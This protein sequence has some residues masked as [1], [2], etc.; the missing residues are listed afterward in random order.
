MTEDARST[1]SGEP[2]DTPVGPPPTVTP[3]DAVGGPPPTDGPTPAPPPPPTQTAPAGAPPPPSGTTTAVMDPPP[4]PPP[5]VVERRRDRP[6]MSLLPISLGVGLLAAAIVLSAAR[7]RSDGDLDWSNYTVGL[8]AT[9][10]LVLVALVSLLGG[11]GRTREELATW[12]G[13]IGVLGVGAMLGVGLEDVSGADDWLPYLVGGVV[14]LL[15]VLGYVAIRRGAFVV[16]AILGLGLVYLQAC[17]D[18]LSDIGDDDGAIVA[19]AA[20]AVFVLVVTAVGW[21]LPTRALSGVVAGVVGVIGFNGVLLVLVIS[22][23]FAPFFSLDMIGGEDG[24]ASGAEGPKADFDTD[25]YVILALAAVLTLVWALAA[26]LN[27][28]PGFTVL[29]IAMPASVVPTATFVLVVDHP[30]WW[31]A[32]LAVA[33][34]LVLALVGLQQ[35]LARKRRA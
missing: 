23:A 13:A 14:V 21:I 30:T 6:G 34:T 19:A 8:G 2:K 28:N 3:A 12:P 11:V 16:T 29:A 5:A 15:S 31:G 26:A 4:P 17:D 7:T 18:L 35:L 24:A 22:Q 10:V 9:A 27:G 33:G 1:G 25:V 32:A 20:V